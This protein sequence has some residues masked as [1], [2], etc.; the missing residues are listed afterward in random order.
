M[1]MVSEANHTVDAERLSRIERLNVRLTTVVL[2]AF[3][4][5]D[6]HKVDMR[7]LA[8]AAGM[9]FATIYKYYGDKEGLLFAFIDGWLQE[10]RSEVA[11]AMATCTG[12]R[13][14]VRTALE[15]YLRYYE[16][17][18]KIGRVVF[19]TVPM[20]TWMKTDMFERRGPIGA[21]EDV[22]RAAQA[23]GVIS[24]AIPTALAV[25]SL[26]GAFVRVFVM[27]QHRGCSY[28]LTGQLPA[29]FDLFWEGLQP[30]RV[31]SKTDD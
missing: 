12:H 28:S 5:T 10:L 31:V 25:D 9:S 30:R 26:V 6:F 4:D 19:M 20:Q 16:A 2:D 11:T 22:L 27:W 7:S 21:L 29:L 23:E 15:C 13:D 3:A 14:K 18:P 8:E 1:T 24:A 17:N